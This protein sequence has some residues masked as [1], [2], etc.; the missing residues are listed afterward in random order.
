MTSRWPRVLALGLAAWATACIL[1][2]LS[3]D[4]IFIPSV[5]LLGSFVVPVTVVFWLLE[6][7]EA[8]ELQP[9]R[10][11]T[12]FLFAGVLGMVASGSLETWLLPGRVFPNLW[13]GLI[14]E[15]AKG[16][17]VAL[18]ARGLPAYRARDGLILGA[19]VGFGFAAFETSGYALRPPSPRRASRSR[20]WSRSRSCARCSRRSG[21]ASGPACSAP[22]CSARGCA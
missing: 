11:L 6:H 19:T 9:D 8:T 4:E 15:A 20:T 18:M 5:I 3:D 10:L 1:Y 2:F 14:E 22:R 12:A 16:I 17:A 7:R 21:T 13:V